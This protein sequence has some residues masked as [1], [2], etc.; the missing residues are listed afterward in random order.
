MWVIVHIFHTSSICCARPRSSHSGDPGSRDEPDTVTVGARRR[1]G[2][3]ATPRDSFGTSWRH[4]T[5]HRRSAGAVRRVTSC[6]EMRPEHAILG[7]RC[8]V[9]PTAPECRLITQA[10]SRPWLRRWAES[11]VGV[12]P[13]SWYCG[14]CSVSHTKA[15]RYPKC[16]FGST[17]LIIV[18][19]VLM[20]TS[21]RRSR[22]GVNINQIASILRRF[23]HQIQYE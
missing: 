7:N 16:K 22:T 3:G 8:S 9:K 15:E 12:W 10:R 4:V 14:G 11:R 2:S 19:F 1:G 20:L 13:C 5:R 18:A 17:L 6:P 23:I 21:K